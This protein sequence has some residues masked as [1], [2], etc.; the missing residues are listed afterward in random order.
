VSDSSRVVVARRESA[1]EKDSRHRL[2]AGAIACIALVVAA[3]TVPAAAYPRPGRTDQV[4][5]ASDGTRGNF[6]SFTPAISADGRYVAFESNASNL[7]EG[8]TNRFVDVFVHDRESGA[9]ERVSVDSDGNE[10]NGF[11]SSPS[12]SAGGRYVAF[13]SA[14]SN[15][16]EGDT[17]GASDVFVHDRDTGITERVSVDSDWGEGN[18]GSFGPAISADGRYVAFQGSASNLVP[19]DTNAE[20]DVFVHDRETGATERVSLAS[21]GAEGNRSSFA[22]SLSADGRYVAFASLA[23]NLVP[24]DTNGLQDVFVRDRGPV[25]GVG[26]VTSVS[27]ENRILLSGWATLSGQVVASA[28]DPPDDGVPGAKEAG[29][30]LTGASLIYRPEQ[31]D[32]LVRLRLE[33]LPRLGAD[34]C[35]ALAVDGTQLACRE[36]DSA[37]AGI[38]AILWGLRFDLEEIRYEVRAM[39]AAAE[40]AVPDFVLVRCDSE[41][42]EEAPL[43]GGIGTTGAEVRVAVPLS[44]LSAEE[45]Q[46]LSAIEAFTAIGEAAPGPL[47]TLD[48]A[49]LPDA[50]IPPAQVSLG[51]APAGVPEEEVDFE[52]PADLA[53]GSFSGSFDVSSLSPGDH[54]VWARACLGESCGAVSTPVTVAREPV[55]VRKDTNLELTVE[56]RGQNMVLKARLSE[57]DSPSVG[58][59][60]R[61]I[62]FYSDSELIGSKETEGDGIVTV[63]VPPG[64]RG[65]N[66]TYEAVFEGDDFYRGSSNDRPGRGGGPSDGAGEAR[67]QRGRSFP[68]AVTFL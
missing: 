10:G 13:Q 43:S 23:S 15:L 2:R 40:A 47:V 67:D 44:V 28:T 63:S 57:L 38:P 14:A 46:V 53:E 55:I 37:G 3:A 18:A 58:I 11:S 54:E 50:S 9:T 48:Q 34:F 8:D 29:A 22:S 1:T 45:G 16:I 59:A 31:E 12:I 4:S 19:D 32:L 25:V 30:E 60:G 49:D 20:T 24:G 6:G 62:D 68:G 17:N 33:S 66:R 61:T 21:D 39:R 65:A 26:E 42:S 56:A 41:C 27:Q 52:T 5:V 64:H 35:G 51:I 36:V 7:V